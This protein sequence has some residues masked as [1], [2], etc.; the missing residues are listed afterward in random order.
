[1]TVVYDEGERIHFRPI[2]VEGFSHN[3]PA[4]RVYEKAGFVR[5]GCRRMAFYRNGRYR[6][7]SFYSILRREYDAIEADDTLVVM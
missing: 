1:M 2:E 5:E 6:D 4:Q 7:T 3:L